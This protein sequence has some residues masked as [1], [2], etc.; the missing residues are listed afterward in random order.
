MGEFPE[1]GGGSQQ[2]QVE[3]RSCRGQSLPA[4]ACARPRELGLQLGF[5]WSPHSSSF[6][7]FFLKCIA[8]ILKPGDLKK[9]NKN[10]F[11]GFL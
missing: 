6:V 5:T 1:G 4:G 10:G 9:K 8:N 2:E 11:L 7:F 3:R